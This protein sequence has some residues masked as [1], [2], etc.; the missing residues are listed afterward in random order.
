M[1]VSLIYQAVADGRLYHMVSNKTENDKTFIKFK[2]HD[3]VFTFIESP[4]KTKEGEFEHKLLK[5]G[6]K[7]RV[8]TIQ[9]MWADYEELNKPE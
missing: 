3:S 6:E 5:D 9:A 7:A 2:R 4:S 8:G 1:N